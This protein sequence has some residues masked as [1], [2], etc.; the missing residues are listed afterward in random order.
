MVLVIITEAVQWVLETIR[1]SIERHRLERF[2]KG[3]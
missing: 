2:L 1:A 3:L